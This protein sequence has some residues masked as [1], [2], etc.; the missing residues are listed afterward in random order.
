MPLEPNCLLP[1]ELIVFLAPRRLPGPPLAALA[2]ERAH[3]T[4]GAAL[5]K[6]CFGCTQISLS[7]FQGV[8]CCAWSPVRSCLKISGAPACAN[9]TWWHG[10]SRHC[11]VWLMHERSPCRWPALDGPQEAYREYIYTREGSFAPRQAIGCDSR[12]CCSCAIAAAQRQLAPSPA[13][14]RTGRASLCLECAQRLGRESLG[15]RHGS[16]MRGARICRMAFHPAATA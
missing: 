13:T 15:V 12:E 4:L 10:V 16:G 11:E 14:L 3:Q 2:V 7:A 6:A 8:R 9:N 1:F 5:M